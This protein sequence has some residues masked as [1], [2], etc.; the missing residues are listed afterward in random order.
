[1]KRRLTGYDVRS[2]KVVSHKHR[3]TFYSIPKVASRSIISD[4]NKKIPESIIFTDRKGDFPKS[5]LGEAKYFTFAFVRNPWAR[6]VSCYLDKVKY[7]SK[8]DAES[9]LSKFSGLYPGMTFREFVLFLISPMGQDK[10]ADRHWLSQYLF[11]REELSGS[12]LSYIGRFESLDKDWQY[13]C[14]LL[15][16]P[17]GSLGHL[18]SRLGWN[19]NVFTE[20]DK[21]SY[22]YRQYYNNETMHLISK[23]YAKDIQMFSYKF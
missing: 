1:V 18:N 10:Y 21:D 13:V 7:P 22:Y 11:F 14:S 16:V 9:I 19:G 3:F 8:I 17:Q 15:G 12:A 6:V 20:K 23:R 2:E 5:G 4:I